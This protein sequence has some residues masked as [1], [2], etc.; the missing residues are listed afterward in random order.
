MAWAL[1][2][3]GARGEVVVPR[4]ASPTKVEA[5][6]RCGAKL[7][8]HGDDCADTESWARRHAE[9]TGGVYLCSMAW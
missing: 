3:L 8:V 6:R 7:I 4:G 1:R 2:R 5:I 9:E